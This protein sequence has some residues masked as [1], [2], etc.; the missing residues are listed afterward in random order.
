MVQ[1]FQCQL[2]LLLYKLPVPVNMFP[3]QFSFIY[4]NSS[5]KPNYFGK[6]VFLY[7]QTFL[8]E[9]IQYAKLNFIEL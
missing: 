8:D 5:N 6:N 2:K 9:K 1:L 7:D 3:H 4:K